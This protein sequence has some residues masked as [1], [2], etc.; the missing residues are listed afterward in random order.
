MTNVL[1]YS[2]C[3]ELAFVCLMPED[4]PFE[5]HVR[6]EEKDTASQ[7]NDKEFWKRDFP[8]T[9]ICGERSNQDNQ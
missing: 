1:E 3:D 8:D 6:P 4:F 9:V 2:A 5:I 7:N